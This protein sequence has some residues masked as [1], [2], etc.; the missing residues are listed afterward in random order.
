MKYLTL[1]SLILITLILPVY[2]QKHERDMEKE[3]KV[4]Q[5]LTAIAPQTVE[6]FKTA[7]SAL[8]SGKYEEAAKLYEEVRKEAPEFDPVLRRLGL[9]LIEIDQKDEGIRLLEKAVE[10]KR[11]PKNLISLAEAL[12]STSQNDRGQLGRAFNLAQEA[13]AL[14]NTSDSSYLLLIARLS[15]K[16]EKEVDFRNA[17]EELVSTYPDEM[18]SHY[19]N[20]IRLAM[21]EDWIGS[22]K[23]IRKAEALG[24]PSE[25]ANEFLASGVQTRATVWRFVYY[26]LALVAIWIIGLIALFLVG[27]LLSKMTVGSIENDDPNE[28]VTSKQAKLRQTYK[29]LINLA[30]LYYYTSLP[31]VMFLVL[32]ITGSIVYGFLLI[33]RVPIKLV[34]ILAI[35]ALGT[36]YQMVRSLFIKYTPE[37][38]G[39]SLEETEAPDLWALTREVAQTVGTR[40]VDEI[41]I[42][43]GTDLAV[44]ERGSYSERM[45]DQAQRILI[46]GTGVLNGLKQDAFRAVLAHEYGHFNNRDT[47]GGDIALRVNADMI[48]FARGLYES[49]NATWWNIAYWFLRVYHFIFRRISYGAT[50]LQE[51][52]ADRV[53]VIN[54][55]SQPFIEGLGHVV[56]RSIEFDYMASK[57]I[58]E[59]F[60]SR[61]ALQNLYEL[62]NINEAE[63]KK[64]IEEAIDQAINR[65]TSLDDTHPSPIERFQLANRITS[66]NNYSTEGMVWDLF[67]DKEKLTKEMSDLIGTRIQEASVSYE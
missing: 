12:A 62:P 57:E 56:R 27:K 1:I 7:T 4:W 24:L 33:G 60:N 32:A 26:A 46:I 66:K 51:V 6:T 52:L 30:G 11:S 64:E 10:N 15:L 8:D 22:E 14:N 23:E 31:V 39:R 54:Y 44:Y 9:T 16:L 17:T 18:P 65:P 49:G 63:G 55:G 5:E 58:N 61:R 41:R 21:D 43:P 47:A 25:I 34:L 59:A 45:K 67:V 36:V 42:T 37:D 19:M 38:P 53:A 20:A 2:S 35:L 50:R 40:P 13:K 29:R 28:L 3:Q 48:N